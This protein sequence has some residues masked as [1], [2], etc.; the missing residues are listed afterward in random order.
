[1]Q[2]EYAGDC[3]LFGRQRMDLSSGNISVSAAS[4]LLIGVDPIYYG[5]VVKSPRDAFLIEDFV[6]NNIRLSNET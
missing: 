6:K 1:M 5:R 4:L 3:F 2:E